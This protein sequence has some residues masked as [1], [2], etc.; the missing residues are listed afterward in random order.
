MWAN[1][2]ACVALKGIVTDLCRSIHRLCDISWLKAVKLLLH[3]PRP[4]PRK[5]IRLKLDPYR[6]RIRP[7]FIHLAAHLIDLAK[8]SQ[9]VL[10]VVGNLMCHD[11]RRSKIA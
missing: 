2:L 4:Y 6:H 3:G 8:N 5:A 10:D 1:T 11:I 9:L 7:R